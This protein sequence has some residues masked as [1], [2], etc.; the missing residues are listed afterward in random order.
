MKNVKLHEYKLVNTEKLIPY[1]NNTKIH[2]E[3][4]IEKLAN[5]IEKF[6]FIKPIIID[7]EYN[8]LCGHGGLLASKKLGLAKVPVLFIDNLSE[9]EKRAYIIADNKLAESAWDKELLKLELDDLKLNGFDISLTGF[10]IKDIVVD[11]IQVSKVNERERTFEKYNLAYFDA[12]N[13]EGFYDMPIIKKTKAKP[14]ELLGFNYVLSDKDDNKDKFIHFF[15]DDYQFERIWANPY[16]YLDKISQYSGMLSPDFSLYAD[17]SI[18]QQI[19]NIYRSRLIGQLAQ[20]QGI[21]VIP[22]VSWS[23]KRSY[24]FCF[25]GIEKGGTIA[26]STVGVKND[27]ACKKIFFDGMKECLKRVEPSLVINYGGD[28]GFDYK[29]IKTIYFSRNTSFEE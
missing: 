5:S 16:E 2:T 11:D 20:K 17:M 19:Y 8:V 9:N 3:E 29:G 6:G 14:K 23:D 28:I 26:I 22:T 27:K 15:L 13:S 24:K 7:S 21:K 18:S 25:D 10:E 1:K 12:D 4:Q